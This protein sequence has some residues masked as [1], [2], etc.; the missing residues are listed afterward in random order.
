MLAAGL[1]LKDL[2]KGL[3]LDVGFSVLLLLLLG[4]AAGSCKP[5]AVDVL[6]AASDGPAVITYVFIYEHSCK[7]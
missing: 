6:A 4:C 3:S 7:H 2:A 1:K 5:A